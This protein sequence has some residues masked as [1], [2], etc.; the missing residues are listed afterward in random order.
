M[1]IPVSLLVPRRYFTFYKKSIFTD[2]DKTASNS[3][4]CGQICNYFGSVQSHGYTFDPMS[5]PH[6]AY[7]VFDAPRYQM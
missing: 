7:F 4:E 5:A 3:L 1:A 2:V 6:D